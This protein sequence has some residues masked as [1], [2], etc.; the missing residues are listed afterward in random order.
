MI[1]GV[2]LPNYFGLG[3]REAVHHLVIE[4]VSSNLQYFLEQLE[5]FAIEVALQVA[6]L[7]A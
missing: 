3:Y 4:F 7:T 2:N 1:S 6:T 5:R